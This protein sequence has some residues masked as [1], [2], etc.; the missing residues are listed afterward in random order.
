MTAIDTIRANLEARLA[1]LGVEIARLD[2]NR[3]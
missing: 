2:V 3:H 1:A